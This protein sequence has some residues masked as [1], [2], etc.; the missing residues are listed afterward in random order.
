MQWG[1]L[2]D[3]CPQ[4]GMGGRRRICVMY[5]VGDTHPHMFPVGDGGGEEELWH[6]CRWGRS[7]THV[8]SGGWER[9]ICAMYAV[10]DTHSHMF[11]VRGGGGEEELWHVH[12]GGR[13]VTH[14]PSGGWER[15]GGPNLLL[16]FLND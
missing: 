8:S 11:P 1:T 7:V 4:W 3:T 13:S 9:R 15:R 16:S 2:S 14:V 6:V 10:G 12:S 5:T